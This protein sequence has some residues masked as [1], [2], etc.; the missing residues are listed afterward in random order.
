MMRVSVRLANSSVDQHI[1]RLLSSV[2]WRSVA[3]GGFAT[4]SILLQSPISIEDPRLKPFT[5]VYIYNCDGSVLWEGRLQIPGRTA[6]D[7]GEV[8]ELTAI[9]PSGHASDQ[10]AVLIYIDTDLTRWVRAPNNAAGADVGINSDPLGSSLDG[11]RVQFPAGQPITT[12]SRA[13]TGY[14]LFTQS[15]MEIG[16][17]GFSWNAGLTDV[18]YTVQSVT[19]SSGSRFNE[20]PSSQATNGSGVAA[21][22]RWVVDDYPAARVHLTFRMIRGAGGATTVATDT[23]WAQTWSFRVLG[24]RMLKDGTLVS[25]SAGME[26]TIRVRAH[27][28]VADLLGRL[29][30]QYD[31]AAAAVNTSSTVDI[32]QLAYP[33]GATA[34]SVLE[35]LTKLEPAYYWAAWESNTA[36]KYR[37]EWKPWP[38][39]VRY[40]AS[41]ADGF[42]SPA[43]SFEQYNRVVVR[44][45]DYR[46]QIKSTIRT[47]VI[48]EL[49]AEGIVRE[50]MMDLGDE[51]GSAANAQIAGDEFLAEHL[52]P[53][54][55]GTLTIARPIVDAISGKSVQP[56]QIKPG[57]LIRVRGVEAS[58]DVLQAAHRD[59]L[60]IFRIVSVEAGGDGTAQLELDMFNPDEIRAIADLQKRRFRKR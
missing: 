7:Q 31:G 48:P 60:T 49:A 27:Q 30:P 10:T 9:G 33:D 54:S 15:E 34:A 18:N 3:P 19:G 43:P 40:E 16:A 51:V 35:D 8:Y 44:W 12:S 22:S 47:Q 58:M 46:G 6:G 52:Y 28:V 38:T 37:F 42:S 55:G 50:H 5:R 11:L 1:T 56:W 25:G 26:S 21:V 17:Y 23:V 20:A 13:Q 29:L 14:E 59:G 45:K 24:R 36:G 39:T 41:I 4:A 2:S 53:P 32:D 57:E